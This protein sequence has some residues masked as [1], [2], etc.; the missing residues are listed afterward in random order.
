VAPGS[1]VAPLINRITTATAT[2]LTGAMAAASNHVRFTAHGI[3]SCNAAGTLIPQYTLSAA[4]GGAYTTD[5]NSIIRIWPI[6][7]SGSNTSIGT[8][9]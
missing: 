3:V 6:G 8:W 4:P 5:A 7:A 1:A 9:A 2:N